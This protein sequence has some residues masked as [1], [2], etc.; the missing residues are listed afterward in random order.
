M[1]DMRTR[2]HYCPLP[3]ARFNRPDLR[4][5]HPRKRLHTRSMVFFDRRYG[6]FM[7]ACAHNS[8]YQHGPH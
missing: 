5:G 7:L 2:Q 4:F 8:L 3:V 1:C 6:W